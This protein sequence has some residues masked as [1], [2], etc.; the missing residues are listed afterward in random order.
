[1]GKIL[2]TGASGFIGRHLCGAL[3]THDF[4]FRPIVRT[5]SSIIKNSESIALGDINAVTNWHEALIGIDTIIHLAARVHVMNE[6]TSDPWAEF[7]ATN[8]DATVNLAKQAI[9]AGI[10][11]FIFVSTI[12][13]NGE[14]THHQPFTPFDIPAPLDFYG[15]S[16]LEAEIALQKLAQESGLEL[17]IIRSPLVYGPHVRANFYKLMQITKMGLPL[18]FRGVDNRRSMVAIDNLV[19][20]LITCIDHPAAANQ[21]FLVS[22]GDDLSLSRLIQ[23]I[24]KAMNQGIWL[25]PAPIK[26]IQMLA[27]LTGKSAAINRLF[28]SLQVDIS[29]TKKTLNWQPLISVEQGIQKTVQHFLTHK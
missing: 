19:D 26:L 2:V 8:V 22:D 4:S 5:P 15:Q 10:K 18:P 25:L 28:G 16:K 3:Q 1:M 11:R 23:L 21:I 13:V 6:T 9:Q 24:A 12:K 20:L 14:E 29:H 17:V 27:A 7:R